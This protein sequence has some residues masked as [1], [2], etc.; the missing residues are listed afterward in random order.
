MDPSGA[1]AIHCQIADVA[2]RQTTEEFGSSG[3]ER[4]FAGRAV[5]RAL[6]IREVLQTEE[7]ARA[8]QI[9]ALVLE[10]SEQLPAG[11]K[12]PAMDELLKLTQENRQ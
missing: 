11:Y 2:V 6:W 12:F 4:E 5:Q 8:K 1:V 9:A 3:E 10:L 7:D